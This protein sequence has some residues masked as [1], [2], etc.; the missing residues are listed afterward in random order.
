MIM[1]VNS[2][3]LKFENYKYFLNRIINLYYLVFA[4]INIKICLFLYYFLVMCAYLKKQQT[5]NPRIKC[6]IKYFI[7]NI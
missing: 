6:Q 3:F 1:K 5:P 2:S 4:K 7:V